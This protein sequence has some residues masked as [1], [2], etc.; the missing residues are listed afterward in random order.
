[1]GVL[2]FFRNFILRYEFFFSLKKNERSPVKNDWVMLDG[3]SIY[4][5]CFQTVVNPVIPPRQ[6]RNYVP[7]PPATEDDVIDEILCKFEELVYVL[8]P[9]VGL[10]IATDSVAGLSK[11]SQQRKRRFKPSPDN[12]KLSS[13]IISCGTTFILKLDRR[14]DEW[15]TEKKK[16]V[17]KHLK[18]IHDSSTC[19]GEAE[20]SLIHFMKKN[21]NLTY[22]IV[23]PDA[24]IIFLSLGVKNN[25]IYVYREN[26]F[27]EF[28]ADFF[29][30]DINKFRNCIADT[31]KMK[32]IYDNDFIAY[33]FFI[34]NDFLPTVPSLN[35]SNTGI[36]Q[37]FYNYSNLISNF[38]YI[39][40]KNLE[41]NKS[42]MKEFLRIMA[43]NEDSSI[44]DNYKKC[45]PKWP[46]TILEKNINNIKNY[47]KE[48]M[49]IK[50]AGVDPK[51]V[52]H[53]YLLG[54]I[55]VL[56]YY[57][58]KIPSWTWCYPF[59]YA[60]FF[61]VLYEHFDTF[62]FKGFENSEPLSCFE[63]LVA[64]LPGHLNHLLPVGLRW[65]NSS[66]E[67][68]I[69]DMFPIEFETDY[70]GKR[71]EYEGIVKLPVCD[72]ERIKKAVRSCVLKYNIKFTEPKI[73]N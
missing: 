16:G 6:M 2:G 13:T 15:I 31:L 1:M 4:H 53:E 43:E 61:S 41:F 27:R 12:G 26:I 22:T 33:C 7:P 58:D 44:L 57:I 11:C 64:V 73:Y 10:Y 34:G 69:I 30:V 8:N 32:K 52:A 51:V 42:N 20:H 9:Q 25:N 35:I 56:K 19:I 39:T 38:G 72:P 37:L 46:N 18:I 60:P 17:Y 59:H 48:F 63:Q 36:D 65:L 66:P 29:L 55:F 24:D 68:S 5:P 50:F 28:N 40:N 23:S 47:K 67:S 62:E 71:Q 14:I 45:P 70:E 49:E 54:M 21:L 3:N